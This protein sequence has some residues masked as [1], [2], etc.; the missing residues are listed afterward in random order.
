MEIYGGQS[1]IGYNMI[2]CGTQCFR[3][4]LL[5]HRPHRIST[6]TCVTHMYSTPQKKHTRILTMCILTRISHISESSIGLSIFKVPSKPCLGMNTNGDSW[7]FS[8]THKPWRQTANCRISPYKCISID[9][10]GENLSRCAHPTRR[11]CQYLVERQFSAQ[12]VVNFIPNMD[13]TR[14]VETI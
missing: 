10:L 13:I 14:I 9:V 5:Q 1:V 7:Q 3:N 11:S 6:C 4:R 2:M 12:L 8:L